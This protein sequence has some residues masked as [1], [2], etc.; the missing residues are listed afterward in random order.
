MKTLSILLLALILIGAGCTADTEPT[1][2][3][4]TTDTPT[5]TQEI[6]PDLPFIELNLDGDPSTPLSDDVEIEEGFNKIEGSSGIEYE[7]AN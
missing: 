2:A 4:E 5:E 1:A 6:N 3:E 7:D